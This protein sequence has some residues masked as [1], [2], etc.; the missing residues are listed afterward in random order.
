LFESFR[1]STEL[2]AFS[3]TSEDPFL[4]TLADEDFLRV[5]LSY[6]F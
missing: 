6:F 4:R 1:L 3:K 2:R 5:E